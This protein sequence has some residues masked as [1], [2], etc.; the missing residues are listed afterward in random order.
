MKKLGSILLVILLAMSLVLTA[1]GEDTNDSEG[2]NDS[3]NE[4]KGEVKFGVVNWAEGIAMTSLAE[5]VL[6][7][8]MGYDVESTTA[9]PGLIFT[10]VAEGDYDAFLDAWL[11]LTHQSYMDKFGEKIDDLGYN[12]EGAK[13]GL[14]VPSYVDVDSIEEL[15]E[16]K[17]QFEGKI[18]GI[19]SGAG[20]MKATENAIEEYDLDYELMES[21]GPV[22]TAEL[23]SSIDNEEPVIVTGWKPHW[24]FARYDLKFLEDSKKIYGESE[25]IHT[26]ARKGLKEDMPEVAQ[27]LE[28]FNM[29]DQELGSLM[30][31]IAD[32][33]KEPTEIAKKWMNENEDLVNSWLPESK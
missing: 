31:Q 27:F 19:G 11:P 3:N 10:S 1:C 20:I 4:S 32:S 9:E 13:I 5:V 29:N 26:I 2:T 14:V 22:M 8:K 24:K 25:N 28:N 30:G 23:A 12:Y 16:N 18:V 6:E 21:S 33:D 15:N 17:D 7:E